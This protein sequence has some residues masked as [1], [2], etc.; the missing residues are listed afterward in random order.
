MAQG[1]V[2]CQGEARLAHRLYQRG[3]T[4]EQIRAAIDRDFG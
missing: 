2:V 4:L 3:S 1:C